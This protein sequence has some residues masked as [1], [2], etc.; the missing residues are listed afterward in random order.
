VRSIECLDGQREEGETGGRTGSA[1][2]PPCRERK[3]EEE[4]RKEKRWLTGGTHLS[5]PLKRKREGRREVGRLGCL[6]RKGKVRGFVFFSFSFS[7]LIFKSILNSNPFQTFANFSQ[8]F[9][10]LFRDYSSNQNHASQM[11]MHIH[12]LFLT[13][14]YYL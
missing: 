11:M 7:N 13:L 1:A 9:Y 4:E 2:A 5:A 6:G 8:I 3:G 12:L 10:G 14:L